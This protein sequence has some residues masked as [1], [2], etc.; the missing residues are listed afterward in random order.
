MVLYFSRFSKSCTRFLHRSRRKLIEVVAGIDLSRPIFER[1][2]ETASV[3]RHSCPVVV[4]SLELIRML[5]SHVKAIT[6]LLP[7]VMVEDVLRDPGCGVIAAPSLQS[8]TLYNNDCSQ[9]PNIFSLHH[10]PALKHLVLHHYQL[11]WPQPLF[12]F[13]T[14]ETLIIQHTPRSH[15][16][17]IIHGLLQFLSQNPNIKVLEIVQSNCRARPSNN[18]HHPSSHLRSLKT[19]ENRFRSSMCQTFFRKM[20][21]SRFCSYEYGCYHSLVLTFDLS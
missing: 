19:G 3:V 15:V 18:D 13:T 1:D 10:L 14:L 4:D 20:H 8:L 17:C 5:R 16:S 21:Y 6:L 9:L 11:S 7:N 12:Q 2:R